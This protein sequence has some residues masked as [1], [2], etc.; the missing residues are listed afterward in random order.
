M[1]KLLKS[2]VWG[3][4]CGGI[5]VGV[6]GLNLRLSAIYMTFPLDWICLESI[7]LNSSTFGG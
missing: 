5:G 7:Y 2:T 3:S 4:V 6:F 1:L